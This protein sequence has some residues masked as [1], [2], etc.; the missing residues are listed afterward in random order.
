MLFRN[1][2]NARAA[3]A[4]AGTAHFVGILSAYFY[5]QHI[6]HSSTFD[7]VVVLLLIYC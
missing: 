3:V 4:Q 1:I 2:Y 6:K 5:Y 7:I